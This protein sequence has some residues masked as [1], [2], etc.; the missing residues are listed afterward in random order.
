MISTQD[1]VLRM[2]G[3]NSGFRSYFNPTNESPFIRMIKLGVSDFF[4]ARPISEEEIDKRILLC[5]N[6]G[7]TITCG[8]C[9]SKGL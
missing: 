1:N 8:S 6:E 4:E 9:G 3:V 2:P 5:S 7:E